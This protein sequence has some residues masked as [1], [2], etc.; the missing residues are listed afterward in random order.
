MKKT[1]CIAIIT[2]ITLVSSA[3]AYAAE[4]NQHVCPEPTNAV[5]SDTGVQELDSRPGSRFWFPDS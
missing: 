4:I 1:L 3:A 2:G 5:V